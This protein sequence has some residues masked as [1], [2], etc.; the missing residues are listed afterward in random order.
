MLKDIKLKEP[1]NNYQM[2]RQINI[3]NMCIHFSI[4]PVHRE[5]ILSVKKISNYLYRIAIFHPLSTYL[6]GLERKK[7]AA[8]KHWI[9][10]QKY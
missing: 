6:I 8:Y 3:I 7:N 1:L 5:I 2:E 9:N 10:D 4:L